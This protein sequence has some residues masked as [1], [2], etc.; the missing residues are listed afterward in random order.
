MKPDEGKTGSEGSVV[1]KEVQV[2]SYAVKYLRLIYDFKPFT[3]ILVV[4]G[5]LVRIFNK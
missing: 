2:T 4:E 1:V 3:A 5:F